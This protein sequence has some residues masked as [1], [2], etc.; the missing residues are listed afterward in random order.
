MPVLSS[1]ALTDEYEFPIC[2]GNPTHNSQKTNNKDKTIIKTMRL[3]IL[4]P[5]FQIHIVRLQ[6][7]IIKGSYQSISPTF[8]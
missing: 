1:N 2:L 8:Y 5:L 6:L 4:S 7:M 3:F